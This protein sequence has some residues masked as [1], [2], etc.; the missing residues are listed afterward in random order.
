MIESNFLPQGN[1]QIILATDGL[2]N[3]PNY[4]QQELFSFVKNKTDDDIILSVMGFGTDDDAIK[5]MKRLASKGNGSFL[6][7]ENARGANEV[8]IEEI[9]FHSLKRK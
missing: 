2:F 6:Q 9:K 1:N 4:S 3:N 5:L 8:L 7:I